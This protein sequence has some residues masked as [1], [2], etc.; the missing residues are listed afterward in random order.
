MDTRFIY[1]QVQLEVDKHGDHTL[2]RFQYREGIMTEDQWFKGFQHIYGSNTVGSS[3][4]GQGFTLRLWGPHNRDL[5]E[6]L[7]L[8]YFALPSCSS[9]MALRYV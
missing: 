7:G 2:A 1:Q 3:K 8:G 6:K 5:G 4:P 9:L